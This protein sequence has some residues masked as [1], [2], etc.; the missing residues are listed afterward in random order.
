MVTQTSALHMYIKSQQPSAA[1]LSLSL[2]LV[3]GMAA[4]HP[5]RWCSWRPPNLTS[6]PNLLSPH[7]L[8]VRNFT[9]YLVFHHMEWLLLIAENVIDIKVIRCSGQW[10]S[11]RVWQTLSNFEASEH[12]VLQLVHI[13]I[14]LFM[15]TLDF[16]SKS[17]PFFFW[18]TFKFFNTVQALI[19]HFLSFFI[20]LFLCLYTSMFVFH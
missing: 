16:D 4:S 8:E 13:Q 14:N 10:F 18:T 1:G 9:L 7:W 6:V 17:S 15:V 5:A 12:F 3:S 19:I 2:G 11:F 20:Y